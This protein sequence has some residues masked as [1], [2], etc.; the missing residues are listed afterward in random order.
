MMPCVTSNAR[1]ANNTP[2]CLSA[3][4][5]SSFMNFLWLLLSLPSFQLPSSCLCVNQCCSLY[6]SGLLI[7]RVVSVSHPCINMEAILVPITLVLRLTGRKQLALSLASYDVTGAMRFRNS[8]F[9]FLFCLGVIL[10]YSPRSYE[11]GA[12]LISALRG[13]PPA[14]DNDF[15]MNLPFSLPTGL[16][17]WAINKTSIHR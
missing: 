8:Y 10:I 14:L 3:A 16:C 17:H 12:F 9:F 5:P 1:M 13:Q 15:S 4:A 2:F 7:H 6:P 11:A